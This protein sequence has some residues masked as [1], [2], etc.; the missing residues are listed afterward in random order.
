MRKILPLLI[1]TLAACSK[2]QPQQSPT[3]QQQQPQQAQ[4]QQPAAPAPEAKL[5]TVNVWFLDG[6]AM[7]TGKEPLFVPVERKVKEAT[8]QAAMEA[9]FAGPNDQ[10]KARNLRFVASGA[11]GFENLKVENGIAR[12]QLKGTCNAGGSTA[13]IA[14]EIAPTLKQFPGVNAVKIYDEKGKTEEP[15]G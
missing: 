3:Q 6:E 8:P 1:L 14:Q 11:T 13:S 7:K 15:E 10:E 9:L 4:P 2:P 5:A 12:V